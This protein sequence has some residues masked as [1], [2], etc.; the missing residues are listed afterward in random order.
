MD[1]S[2]YI[3]GKKYINNNMKQQKTKVLI[4]KVEKLIKIKQKD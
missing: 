4:E 1:W 3:D 2:G